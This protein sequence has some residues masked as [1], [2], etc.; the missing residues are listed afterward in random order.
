MNGLIVWLLM[1]LKNFSLPI[2]LRFNFINVNRSIEKCE[3][4]D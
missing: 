2:N 4:Y 3:I 1:Y